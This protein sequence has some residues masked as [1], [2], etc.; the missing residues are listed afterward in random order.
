MGSANLQIFPRLPHYV[1]ELFQKIAFF[2]LTF[3]KFAEYC[4]KIGKNLQ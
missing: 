4:T 3:E 2:F 1:Y